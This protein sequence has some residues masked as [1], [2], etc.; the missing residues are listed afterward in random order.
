M[1]STIGLLRSRSRRVMLLVGILVVGLA[2]I[3]YAYWVS[4]PLSGTGGP[5]VSITSPPFQ[6]SIG[7]DK[8]AYAVT[9]NLTVLFSLRNISNKTVT[10][11]EPSRSNFGLEPGVSSFRLETSAEGVTSNRPLHSGFHFYFSWV[12]SNGT[13]MFDTRS[14]FRMAE[15]TDIVLAPDGCLNQ[16]LYIS[17]TEEFGQPLPTGVFQ[18]R[19][20]LSHV[21]IDGNVGQTVTLETPTIA[22]MAN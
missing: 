20:F 5:S 4:L 8:T 11:T 14:L 3:A 19:G 16:T 2:S 21:W 12:Y 10:V 1:G 18:I 22:F 13:V 15:I 7:L 6:L 17:P 9:D